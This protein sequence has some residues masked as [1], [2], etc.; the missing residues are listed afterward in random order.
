MGWFGF[1]SPPDENDRR[2]KGP[3]PQSP[4]V[5][6][7]T[8]AAHIPVPNDSENLND[9]RFEGPLQSTDLQEKNRDAT[10][11]NAPNDVVDRKAMIDLPQQSD[12][13]KKV[14]PSPPPSYHEAPRISNDEYKFGSLLYVDSK[15]ESTMPSLCIEYK[16]ERPNKI[17]LHIQV[18]NLGYWVSELEFKIKFCDGAV[19]LL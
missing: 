3:V 1:V 18:R 2:F 7:T 12:T 17:H 9:R 5:Q 15:A 16:F 19:I 8:R 13:V 4:N 11:I 14:Y 10:G 6:E